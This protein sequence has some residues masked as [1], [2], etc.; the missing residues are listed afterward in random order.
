MTPI[1][2]AVP[3]TASY[4]PR[5]ISMFVV[6]PNIGR[7][8]EFQIAVASFPPNDPVIPFTGKQRPVSLRNQFQRPPSPHGKLGWSLSK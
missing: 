2:R 7:P 4:N 3:V 1:S 8:Q 5:K 6:D